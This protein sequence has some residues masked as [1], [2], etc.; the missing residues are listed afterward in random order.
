MIRRELAYLRA[1]GDLAP[2]YPDVQDILDETLV[3]AQRNLPDKPV[4]MDHWHWLLNRM[5]RVLAEEVTRYRAAD[6]ALALETSFQ[7]LDVDSAEDMVQEGIWEFYQPDAA[8]RI[9]DVVPDES[10]A[11]PE[12]LVARRQRAHLMFRL[13]SYLPT[14]WRRAVELVQIEGMT[15]EDAAASLDVSPDELNAWLVAAYSFLRAKLSDRGLA[16]PDAS[17][18]D[19]AIQVIL[20]RVPARETEDEAEL[21]AELESLAS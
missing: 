5:I 7:A 14:G 4:A 18:A 16:P 11:D 13:L 21:R 1:Q 12:T 20:A 15:P 17:K 6:G 10:G 3:Q 2:D 19:P 9:E 8:L